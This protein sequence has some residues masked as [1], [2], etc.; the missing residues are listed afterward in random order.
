MRKIIRLPNGKLLCHQSRPNTVVIYNNAN[1]QNLQFDVRLMRGSVEN[2][3]GD[4][5]NEVFYGRY[6]NVLRLPDGE[7]L[8]DEMHA[9]A[10]C[11]DRH[12]QLTLF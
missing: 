11:N 3:E 6:D 12:D 5:F 2:L 7:E 8:R 10:S 4:T 1:C 9:L